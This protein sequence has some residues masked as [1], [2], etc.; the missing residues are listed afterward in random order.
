M[1]KKNSVGDL[2]SQLKATPIKKLKKRVDEDNETIGM[3]SN[4]YLNL[5]DGKT[6]KIR[7]F[8]A[9]PGVEDFYIPKKCYWLTVAGRD[10]DARRTTVL[11]SKLHGGTK[12][13]LVEEY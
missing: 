7:I 10:G 12:Y 11:D 8:P 3:Q 13:D 6:L 2:R 5:E 9:H 4:E 1:A